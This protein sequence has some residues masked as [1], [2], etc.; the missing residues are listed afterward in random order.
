METKERDLSFEQR[1]FLTLY[2]RFYGERYSA[3]DAGC[4]AKAQ[5][6]TYLLSLKGIEIGDYGFAWDGSERLR[7]ERET[8]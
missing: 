1:A 8:K 7:D 4:K 2:E 6:M 5:F 3:K